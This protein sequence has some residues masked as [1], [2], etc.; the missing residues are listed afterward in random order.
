MTHPLL[1]V[2]CGTLP[3]AML[4]SM[5]GAISSLLAS[6]DYKQ[7]EAEC[8]FEAPTGAKDVLCVCYSQ[9]WAP[10]PFC[11]VPQMLRT[12]LHSIAHVGE[13]ER[14]R[15]VQPDHTLG[16]QVTLEAPLELSGSSCGIEKVWRK[17]EEN[18]K[19][20]V[21][22]EREG[23]V[24]IHESIFSLALFQ[25]QFYHGAQFLKKWMML[26]SCN[27]AS[28][29]DPSVLLTQLISTITHCTHT[30]THTHTHT[31]M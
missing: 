28:S 5:T 4:G 12:L 3:G 20:K 16:Q 22:E 8:N 17:R 27:A 29:S 24:F 19:D 6:P 18:E 31:T 21:I 14:S 30:H 26:R 7:E 1:V 25:M 9:L 23:K 15:L 2:G 13:E 10:L 11:Q